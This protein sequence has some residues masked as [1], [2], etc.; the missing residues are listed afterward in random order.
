L[1]TSLF[2]RLRALLNPLAVEIEFVPVRV[3]ALI[4]SHSASSAYWWSGGPLGEAEAPRGDQIPRRGPR[5]S[6]ALYA[7]HPRDDLFP[8]HFVPI[9]VNVNAKAIRVRQTRLRPPVDTRQEKHFGVLH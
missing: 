1:A 7:E 9:S 3:A 2:A 5:A 4:Y 8:A 6:F